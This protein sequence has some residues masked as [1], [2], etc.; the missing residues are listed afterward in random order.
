[1]AMGAMAGD[2]LRAEAISVGGVGARMGDAS[3]GGDCEGFVSFLPSSASSTD[4]GSA[5]RAA[6]ALA[7]GAGDAGRCTGLT[8]VG[9]PGRLEGRLAGRLPGRLPGLLP[10]RLPG[11]LPG[12]LPGL[13]GAREPGRD[14]IVSMLAAKASA[15][16]IARRASSPA[17][18]TADDAGGLTGAADLGRG[19]VLL[20]SG[21]PNELERTI[22]AAL[23]PNE[24]L[25]TR[26]GRPSPR[27]LRARS[28]A[29]CCLVL[30]CSPLLGPT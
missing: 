10:G 24:F 7:K 20:I 1:M 21:R 28:S 27:A 15:D 17:A 19:A 5:G 11:L 4:G 6:S 22:P 8:F 26:T 16:G 18:T 14:R 3:A 30:D 13:L 29:A 12:R 2:A 23:L 25:R 9:L